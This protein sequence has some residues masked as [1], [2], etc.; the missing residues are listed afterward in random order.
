MAIAAKDQDGPRP[1][2][3]GHQ[4]ADRRTGGAAQGHEGTDPFKPWRGDPDTTALDTS[5]GRLNMGPI[6][7]A[8]APGD[9]AP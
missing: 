2:L 1:R 6:G 9:V 3:L 8:L 7:G 4:A 5:L